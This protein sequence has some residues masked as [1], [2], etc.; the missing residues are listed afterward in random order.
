M[1]EIQLVLRIWQRPSGKTQGREG[2][3]FGDKHQLSVTS[4]PKEPYDE[5]L[6]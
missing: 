3:G 1:S 5:V 4:F 2:T 6:T